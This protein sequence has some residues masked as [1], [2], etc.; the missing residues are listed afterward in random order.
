MPKFLDSFQPFEGKP[1]KYGT[2]HR[3]RHPA[4]SAY[5]RNMKL[6]EKEDAEL[7]TELYDKDI[8]HYVGYLENL[9]HDNKFLHDRL[10]VQFFGLDRTYVQSVIQKAKDAV[11]EELNAK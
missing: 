9:K 5:S 7:H 3:L 11:T 8:K 10:W 4:E 1:V 6:L 2:G